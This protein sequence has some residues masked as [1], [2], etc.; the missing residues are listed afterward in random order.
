MNKIKVLE[1]IAKLTLHVILVSVLSAGV[2]IWSMGIV[3]FDDPYLSNAE[4]EALGAKQ[5]LV[6]A[7]AKSG[8]LFFYAIGV[9]LHLIRPFRKK[10][11]LAD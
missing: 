8:A 4:Y 5:D 2:I 11:A 7:W 6:I 3:P 10:S 9:Y 1:S